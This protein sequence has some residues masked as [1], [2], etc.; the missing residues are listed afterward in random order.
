LKG[1]RIE[2]ATS[3]ARLRRFL[4]DGLDTLA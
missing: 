1:R 4:A 2:L 3:P